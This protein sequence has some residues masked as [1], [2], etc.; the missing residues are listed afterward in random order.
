M[1]VAQ[2][3]NC[4]SAIALVTALA[5][6]APAMAQQAAA[7]PQEPEGLEVVIVTASGGNRTQINSSVSVTTVNAQAIADFKP[8]S[9]SELLRMIPG[10]QVAGTAG[11]G[12]NSNI[13]VRGLPVAT[14]GSPF[15]Q[16]QEDGLPTVLFGDI[17]FGNNDYWTRFDASVAN[18]EGVRGGSAS[19]Y[20]SQAPGAVINYISNTGQQQGGY[21]QLSTGLGFSENRLDF[22]YGGPISDKTRFHVGGYYK[23][24]SGPLDAGYDVSNSYQIKGNLT[25]DFA[26]NKG[27]VRVLVKIAD[28]QEPN[29]TGSPALA[30]ING[31]EVSNIEPF[32]GFDGRE[33]SNYSVYNKDFLIFNRDGVLERV[34]MDGITTKATSLGGQLR[35]NV[36]DNWSVD[37]NFRWTDM[38]GGFAAP[39]LNVATRA[40]VIGSVISRPGLPNAT[41]AS[42]RYAAGPKAGQA[43]T[44]TYVDNNVNVRTNIRDIGSTAN[45]FKLTGKYDTGFGA[46]TARVGYFYM[47]QNIAMDWHVNKS[48]RELSGNNPSQL[49]LFDAAGNKLTQ[50]GI[51]GYNNNWGDCCARDYDLSYTNTAPYIALELDAEKFALD[52]SVRFESVEASGNTVAG[53]SEF[54]VNSGGVQIATI[55]ANGAREN[56]NYTRDYTSWSFGA[57]Y[58]VNEDT[59]VFLRRSKGGRFNGDRQTVSG[60]INANGSL[61]QA[62]RTASVDFVNQDELG[63]KNR[64]DLLGGRY[65]LEFTLLQGDFKQ[66]TF[67]LSAT[68]CPGGSGGCVIDA[69]YE[70]SGAEAYA[71][72]RNGPLSVIGNATYSN[73]KISR[74][75][76]SGVSGPFTRAPGIPDLSFTVAANYDF[77]DKVTLGVSTTGQTSSI[78]D[79]GREYPG[80]AIL[81]ATAKYSLLKNVELSLSAYNL[82]DKFDLR[83]NGGVA[84][85]AVN[86]V[87]I[88]GN[89]ALGRT[90][91]AAIR[92][93][94]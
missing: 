34:K 85:S 52:G 64:G 31:L 15:V 69:K 32:P 55:R 21:A 11:P 7:A 93:T 50:E 62:G 57:L 73:A 45:D 89:P 48:L 38:S 92:Y 67:E 66:S 68:R 46:V 53:G 2:F 54:L 71:T 8:S 86:P 51:S 88:S 94:F 47:K 37:N 60:K 6:G 24:G 58:K 22:R 56:L 44:D 1:K 20:A 35:Y 25:H 30:S 26:D 77:N 28:T 65:T 91:T 5:A 59:S 3:S 75:N 14:G 83:G 33:G 23:K 72:Y 12:G 36:N 82:F 4:V 17:Q 16:L 13:A 19:T 40:S 41:V 74:P 79:A 43:F 63:V 80:G 29:Y 39:F 18:V 10:I 81:N 84:N 87:V 27:F 90:L 78:D 70:S 61:T 9:E 42:I 49:D 76:G